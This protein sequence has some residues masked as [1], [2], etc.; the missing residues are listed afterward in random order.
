MHQRQLER[1]LVLGYERRLLLGR[2]PDRVVSRP[3]RLGVACCGPIFRVLSAL[4]HE[5]KSARTPPE[6]RI[7]MQRASASWASRARTSSSVSY[8]RPSP[9]LAGPLGREPEGLVRSF[10]CND[11][12][13]FRLELG[14]V[15]LSLVATVL[16]QP[17]PCV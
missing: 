8:T 17:E 16:C 7:V 1:I 3:D 2:S 4:V 11:R 6:I 5:S 15:A 14:G 9:L 10:V 13:C 12:L